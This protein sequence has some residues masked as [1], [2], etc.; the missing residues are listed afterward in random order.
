MVVRD[1]TPG[2]FVTATPPNA[3]YHE[4]SYKVIAWFDNTSTVWL[5]RVSFFRGVK[6]AWH[7]KSGRLTVLIGFFCSSH[8]LHCGLVAPLCWYALFKIL[9]ALIKLTQ[10]VVKLYL[11]FTIPCNA[12][13]FVSFK[14]FALTTVYYRD[15]EWKV[16]YP[17]LV[18]AFSKYWIKTWCGLRLVLLCWKLTRRDT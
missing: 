11:N 14:A 8:K 15:S 5:N 2:L 7:T 12:A 18:N 10:H 6:P 17:S 3:L 4:D 1:H 9:T 13:L 16:H